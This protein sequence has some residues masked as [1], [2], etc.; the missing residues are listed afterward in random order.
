VIATLTRLAILT[1]FTSSPLFIKASVEDSLS[2]SL[3]AQKHLAKSYKVTARI[4]SLGVFG[5]GGMI[6]NDNPAFD[7]NFTYSGK[8]WGF[9]VFKAFDLR[10]VH[11]PYNFSLVM[12]N[13]PFRINTHF[14]F[15]PYAGFVIE[16][17]EKLIGHESDGMVFLIT[18]YKTHRGF[19]F[20]HCAR[21]SNTF[22]A[23]EDFDWLNRFKVIYSYRHLEASASAWHNNTLFD[24]DKH[25]SAGISLGYSKIKIAKH[26][27]ISSSITGIKMTA[28]TDEHE[29][30][31]G[32]GLS[33]MIAAVWE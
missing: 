13:K 28:N 12:V 20:E 31:T 25:T 23:T 19:T 6:A 30:T 16:Q 18:S 2:D 33:F 14:T 5:Y 3:H 29:L 24:H 10:D 27:F 8:H 32:S 26:V 22:F 11:S 21:F 4:H 17:T 9:F 7:V 15:T 1:V